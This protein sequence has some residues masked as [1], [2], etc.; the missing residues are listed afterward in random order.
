[1]LL[2]IVAAFDD[3]NVAIGGTNVSLAAGQVHDVR[4]DAPFS[5]VA[6]RPV[7]AAQ[8]LLGAGELEPRSEQGDPSLVALVPEEQHRPDYVFV[9]PTSYAG[10]TGQSYVVIT[11]PTGASVQLDGARL[12][13]GWASVDEGHEVLRV[14]VDG[15]THRIAAEE[16]VGVLVFGL[17]LDTSYA[18][19]AGLELERI[20]LL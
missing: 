18:Y 13:E 5:L 7:L 19:P 15:G 14:E 17:G 4:V 2:R 6:S 20:V 9:T 1:N 16:N 8:F 12:E 3:T 11:R 10:A